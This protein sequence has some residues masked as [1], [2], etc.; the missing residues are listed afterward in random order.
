MTINVAAQLADLEGKTLMQAADVAWTVRRALTL[1]LTGD[2]G[3][4]GDRP[5]GEEKFI[6]GRL[7]QRVQDHDEVEITA[8]EALVMKRV[9]GLGLTPLFVARIWPLLEVD[10]PTAGGKG[11]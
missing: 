7:A 2:W 11:A 5:T 3:M 6:R 1:A 10:L 4:V 9:V 8:E